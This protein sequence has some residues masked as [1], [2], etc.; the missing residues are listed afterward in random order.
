MY[1]LQGKIVK[2]I[3]FLGNN[4][5][6]FGKNESQFHYTVRT[7]SKIISS[8]EID[9]TNLRDVLVGYKKK[10]KILRFLHKELNMFLSF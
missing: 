6:S 3:F 2:K 7:K 10:Q 8:L 9:H 5:S 1:W 4:Y